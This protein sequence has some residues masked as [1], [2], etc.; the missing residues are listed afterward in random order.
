M[1][2]QPALIDTQ[3]RDP[4]L[5]Q[6]LSDAG[7]MRP[8]VYDQCVLEQTRRDALLRMPSIQRRR[9]T[10]RHHLEE[11][12]GASRDS[13]RH[14]H[15][16]LAVCSLPYTRQPL[17]VREWNRTQG[18]MKLSVTAGKL[19]SPDGEWMEQPLP[20]GSRARLML[21]HVCSE[22]IRTNSPVVHIEDS[23]CE[24]IKALGFPVTGG[25]NGTISSFK[26]QINALTACTLHI[27][28]WDGEKARTIKAS[29][30][31][32][33]AVEM[34]TSAPNQRTLWPTE[35]NLSLD[36]FQT[37]TKHALPINLHAAR[38]FANSPRKLDL[39][40][41]LGY[42]LHTLK[43]PLPISWEKLA[44]Q[45]GQN[46]TRFANFKRD[47]ALELSEIKEVFPK[48]PIVLNDNGCIISPGSSEVLALPKRK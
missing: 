21:L 26:Q 22:A 4:D 24:F 9:S 10:I 16:V 30:F 35:L 18:R 45:W 47:F 6:R 31:S 37:L 5:I 43:E 11:Q 14:I 28:A 42:R 17:E 1:S 33:L 20:Y 2:I 36:F 44:E 41:W 32:S 29:P 23:L 34:F 13:I 46:Y 8:I 48:L 12:G 3:V 15:S 19:M 7:A 25:K 27:G 40:F 39:I 38:A